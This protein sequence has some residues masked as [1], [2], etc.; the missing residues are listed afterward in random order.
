MAAAT[1][2]ACTLLTSLDELT[3]GAPDSGPVGEGGASEAAAESSLPDS[4]TTT[5]ADAEA[6]IPFCKSIIGFAVCADFD[7]PDAAPPAPFDS[8]DVTGANTLSYDGVDS[9]STPRSFFVTSGVGASGITSAGVRYKTP[10][11]ATEVVVE[12]DFKGEQLGTKPFDLVNFTKSGIDLSVE[13]TPSG[14]L[15]FDYAVPDGDGGTNDGVVKLGSTSNGKWQ[16]L[17]WV[18][19][20]D[21]NSR[22]KVDISV[23]GVN[24]GSTTISQSLFI[25]QPTVE[26]SDVALEPTTTAWK[27]RMD[28]IVVYVK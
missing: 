21:V 24:V 6:S 20:K 16:H 13:I 14:Q 23:D 11:I 12:L 1:L 22:F 10:V 18:A 4:G 3:A 9:V 25:G 8:L 19:K 5:D 15:E 28:N 7:D 17:K 27:V 2:T 26:I